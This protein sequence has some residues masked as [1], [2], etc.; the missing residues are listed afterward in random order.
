VPENRLN[1]TRSFVVLLVEDEPL[2]A[3]TLVDL[4]EELGHTPVEAMTAADALRVF[5]VRPD[6]D[7]L[8]TDIGLP[9]RPG[10]VLAAECRTLVPTLPVIFATGHNGEAAPEGPLPVPPTLHLA[11][12]FQMDE[13]QAAITRVMASRVAA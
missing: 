13:L 9:D 3:L 7:L 8:V 4:L 6:I 12:P 2:I 5:R 1:E 11:K 10:D